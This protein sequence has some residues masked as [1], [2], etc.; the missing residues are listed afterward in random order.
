MAE[1]ELAWAAGFFDGEGNT[2]AI[3]RRAKY[4]SLHVSI[5]QVE[6]SNL[7]RFQKAIGLGKINGPYKYEKRPREKPFYRFRLCRQ[8]DIGRFV[9]LVWKYLSR[10]KR[11]QIN[12][13]IK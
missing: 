6:K 12:S 5:T 9:F 8:A 10:P 11:D 3:I 13:S 1:T 7:E 2:R 4:K